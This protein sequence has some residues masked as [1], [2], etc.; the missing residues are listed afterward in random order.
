VERGRVEHDLPEGLG[1]HELH[2]KGWDAKM[3][4]RDDGKNECGAKWVMEV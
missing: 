1:Q 3:G 2:D 4:K